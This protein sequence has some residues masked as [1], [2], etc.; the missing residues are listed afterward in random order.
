MY[1]GA[2]SI[3]ITKSKH[4][5]WRS[6]N[7]YLE[8]PFPLERESDMEDIRRTAISWA[9]YKK[10]LEERLGQE[11][12]DSLGPKPL[13]IDELNKRKRQAEERRQQINNAIIKK[14]KKRGGRHVQFSKEAR[15]LHRLINIAEGKNKQVLTKQLQDLKLKYKI[16]NKDNEQQKKKNIILLNK[17]KITKTNIGIEINK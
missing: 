9:D 5:S 10:R 14:K 11:D 15:N 1:F 12:G 16:A 7:I 17:T 6:C 3:V 4:T 2:V 13:T 8:L